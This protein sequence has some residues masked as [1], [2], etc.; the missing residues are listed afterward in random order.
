MCWG[1]TGPAPKASRCWSIRHDSAH[2]V[3]PA[4]NDLVD[5]VDRAGHLAEIGHRLLHVTEPVGGLAGVSAPLALFWL[6]VG[7]FQQGRELSVNTR[8]LKEQV[9]ETALLAQNSAR[10]AA[11]AE[12]QASL[13]QTSQ[14]RERFREIVDAQPVLR[15][16]NASSA[17]PVHRIN[18]RNDGGPVR[19][20]KVEYGGPHELTFSPSTTWAS[21]DIGHLQLTQNGTLEFPV[22]FALSYIDRLDERR[23]KRLRMPRIFDVDEVGP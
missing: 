4:W 19:D 22:D 2:S 6:V 20:L 13:T 23:S 17:G 16:T 12:L 7:Y 14:Q 15:K 3:R 11:A 9:R 1:L 10:Q 21:G 8:A 18:L 5:H